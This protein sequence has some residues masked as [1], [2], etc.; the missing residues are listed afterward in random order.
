MPNYDIYG[1]VDRYV[2]YYDSR[3][4]QNEWYPDHYSQHPLWGKFLT[5]VESKPKQDYLYPAQTL[6]PS[7]NTLLVAEIDAA[8]MP[9]VPRNPG[10]HGIGTGFMVAVTTRPTIYPSNSTYPGA[11]T[12]PS[13]EV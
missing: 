10:Q 9:D 5:K 1:N 6:F 3:T 4:D 8:L 7:L 13:E 2:L 12:F 11:S